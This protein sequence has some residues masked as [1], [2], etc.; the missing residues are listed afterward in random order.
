MA[1]H[2]A[3]GPFD[4]GTVPFRATVQVRRRTGRVTVATD[5]LPGDFEG[6]PIRFQA[7]G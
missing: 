1:L 2:A 7:I 4:L 5:P 6:I 3:I